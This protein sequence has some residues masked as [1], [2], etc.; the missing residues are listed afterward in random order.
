MKY[1]RFVP[2]LSWQMLVFPK[3]LVKN[4]RVKERC[5]TSE[6]AASS[7]GGEAEAGVVRDGVGWR[8]RGK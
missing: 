7:S 1:P 3:V 8:G 2:S 6:V 4:S 5:R